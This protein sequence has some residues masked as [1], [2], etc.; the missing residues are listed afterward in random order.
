MKINKYILVLCSLLMVIGCKKNEIPE[1]PVPGPFVVITTLP[2]SVPAA[3]GTY[4][5]TI[6]ATTNGWWLVIPNNSNWLTISRRYGSATV[7]QD[8]KIAEN[9]TGAERAVEVA[10]NATNGQREVLSIKQEK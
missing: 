5:L 4:K 10:I 8:V 1:K 6:E 9:K 7:S 2:E 3:G